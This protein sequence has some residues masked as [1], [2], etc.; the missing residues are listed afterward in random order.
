[1]L[2]FPPATD[3]PT[4]SSTSTTAC[5][6]RNCST[7][8]T[9][10]TPSGTSDDLTVALSAGIAGGVGTAILIF[11]AVLSAIFV[12]YMCS[13]R[14]KSASQDLSVTQ[15][16]AY[17]LNQPHN[18]HQ[19]DNHEGT[20]TSQNTYYYIDPLQI[21]SSNQVSDSRTDRKIN[22]QTNDTIYS[23]VDDNDAIYEDIDARQDDLEIEPNSAYNVFC[24]KEQVV[25]YTPQQDNGAS[26]EDPPYVQMCS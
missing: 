23:V 7:E 26:G 10:G 24:D 19:G 9:T 3:P 20:L 17:G 16:E 21:P 25:H 15:N 2:V 1:M 18:G 6:N 13:R 5:V 4:L 11:A 12:V 22:T 14:R 8:V